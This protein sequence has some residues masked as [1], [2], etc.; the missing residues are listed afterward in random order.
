MFEAGELPEEQPFVFKIPAAKPDRWWRSFIT[1]NAPQ[2]R[3]NLSTRHSVAVHAYCAGGKTQKNNTKP[4]FKGD[5]YA[6]DDSSQ[7]L[8]QSA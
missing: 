2:R 6:G 4:G 7:H 8:L 3:R 1:G 5:V